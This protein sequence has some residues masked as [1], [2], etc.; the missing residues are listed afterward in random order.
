MEMK[1]TSVRRECILSNSSCTWKSDEQSYYLLEVNQEV[2]LQYPQNIRIRLQKG[3]FFIG[4]NVRILNTASTE[5]EIIG[6]QF[7]V[8]SDLEVGS[9]RVNPFISKLFNVSSYS[10]QSVEECEAYLSKL[11]A[12][13]NNKIPKKDSKLV[14]K[15]TGKI[16]TRLININRYIRHNYSEP[17]TLTL[18]ADLIQ[19]NPV[20]LSNSYSKVF[21]ISPIKHLLQIRMN[22]AEILLTSSND[23]IAT[24]AS[25][26]GYVSSSQFSYLFRRFH[27]M[28]PVQYRRKGRR[29]IK[30]IETK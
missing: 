17:I 10:R 2:E 7:K 21:K 19:C 30:A 1:I 11:L 12:S 25:K 23:S 3:E 22:K 16:D 6:L 29:S 28:T 5:A 15:I 18:L 8:D 9:Y 13:I 24:I 4:R 14:Q 27:G 26:L 20:Y